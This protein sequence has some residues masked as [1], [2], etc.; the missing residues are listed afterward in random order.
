MATINR[1]LV[2]GGLKEVKR[3]F[4]T[5]CRLTGIEDL[6]KHDFR[7]AYVTRSI[8]AGIPP[9]VVL[10]ASGHN[11]DEWKQY[12]NVTPDMLH[13]LFTPLE[14]QKCEAV[15]DYGFEVMRQLTA[16]LMGSWN[17]GGNDTFFQEM[18]VKFATQRN[19]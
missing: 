9:A 13:H 5:A 11:T 10:K 12:L 1:G 18:L 8:L 4:N 15:K 14:G 3:S 19:I 17:S 16:A 2:F 6:H 7:H